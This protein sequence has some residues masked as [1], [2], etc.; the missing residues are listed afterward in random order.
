MNLLF[1]GGRRSKYGLPGLVSAVARV[2]HHYNVAVRAG[3]GKRS[4]CL[5]RGCCQCGNDLTAALCGIG[6]RRC[7]LS[8]RDAACRPASSGSNAAVRDFLCWIQFLCSG[9]LEKG[10]QPDRLFLRVLFDDQ[11]FQIFLRN[12][13]SGNQKYQMI[14]GN[15]RSFY[16]SCSIIQRSALRFRSVQGN[17][18]TGLASIL[19]GGQIYI[20][21]FRGC[22]GADCP[23]SEAAERPR[24]DTAVFFF[25]SFFTI[26]FVMI[27]S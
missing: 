22:G 17:D 7:F 4:S 26:S 9:S 23:V 11:A 24:S 10:S 19:A 6:F 25:C 14:T 15:L 18:H 27:H 21:H 8:F 16:R 3:A 2:Q 13:A 1:I 12:A 5:S 20:L